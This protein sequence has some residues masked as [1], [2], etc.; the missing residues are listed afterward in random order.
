MPK[1]LP[2]FFSEKKSPDRLIR[3]FFVSG[4]GSGFI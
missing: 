1:Q 4:A 3:G 2:M